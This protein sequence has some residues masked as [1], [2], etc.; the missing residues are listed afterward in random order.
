MYGP[1]DPSTKENIAKV[2]SHFNAEYVTD[3]CTC[4]SSVSAMLSRVGWKSLQQHR[5]ILKVTMMFWIV[6]H[7]IDIPD[8]LIPSRSFTKEIT[9]LVL[10]S[11]TT[12]QKDSYLPD[13]ICLW[14]QLPE[15]VVDSPSI[16]VFKTESLACDINYSVNSIPA[17]A[18]F[19]LY[20]YKLIFR[21]R[22]CQVGLLF[23]CIPTKC[24]SIV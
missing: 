7:L 6:N 22:F 8:Q 20:N 2:E 16:N 1:W 13:T 18:I 17:S 14:N 5:A 3:D 12:L 11:W 23:E 15:Q 9:T 10:S 19:Y 21:P 4:K 24:V